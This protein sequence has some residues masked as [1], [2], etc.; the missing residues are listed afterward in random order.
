MLSSFLLVER[1]ERREKE[2]ERKKERECVGESR[3]FAQQ[4][5][6]HN[7]YTVVWKYSVCRILMK[8]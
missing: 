6:I 5:K 7:I 8:I 3:N 1:G 2:R 4:S